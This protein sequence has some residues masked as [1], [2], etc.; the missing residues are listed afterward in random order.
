MTIMLML[1][2]VRLRARNS[3][4]VSKSSTQRTLSTPPCSLQLLAMT[5]R[6][7]IQ[8]LSQFLKIFKNLK[9]KSEAELHAYVRF[10][11]Y[12]SWSR[13]SNTSVSIVSLSLKL[14][15]HSEMLSYEKFSFYHR[16]CGN[17][18][19]FDAQ[20]WPKIFLTECIRYSQQ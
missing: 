10:H 14:L 16:H 7:L 18:F 9:I 2:S 19:E 8:T 11:S 17:Q 20:K 13:T 1:N 15:L 5:D 4:Q 12:R 3:L 6:F